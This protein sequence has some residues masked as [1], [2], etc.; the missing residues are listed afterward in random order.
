[1]LGGAFMATTLAVFVVHGL[2]AQAF[3]R[4]VID[5]PRVLSWMRRAVPPRSLVSARGL[6][7]PKG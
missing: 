6:R 4:A 1:L 3:R 5:S 2:R 7:S